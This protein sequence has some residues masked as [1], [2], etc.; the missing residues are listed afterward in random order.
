[1]DQTNQLASQ[2]LRLSADDN[3]ATALREIPPGTW[4]L[5]DGTAVNIR[6]AIPAA[7]KVPLADI[8]A[9]E[10]VRKYGYVIGRANEAI[11]AGSMVHVHNMGSTVGVSRGED[12]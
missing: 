8:P 11:A 9:G 4:K 1:M 6:E 5:D 12:A 7:F 2:A 10:P 3:V